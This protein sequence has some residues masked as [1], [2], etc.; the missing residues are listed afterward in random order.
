MPGVGGWLAGS[1][2]PPSLTLAP[3]PPG[4]CTLS[5]SHPP[6]APPGC[7]PYLC[8]VLRSLSQGPQ[9]AQGT[10]H[11]PALALGRFTAQTL[12]LPGARRVSGIYMFVVGPQNICSSLVPS[13]L[14]SGSQQELHKYVGH[15]RRGNPPSP[16]T[17]A[18]SAGGSWAG[19]GVSPRGGTKSRGWAGA[20][21]RGKLPRRKG[22]T[23]RSWC[24]CAQRLQNTGP[25][26]V[27]LCGQKSEQDSS[28][29][30]TRQGG[31]RD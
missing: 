20:S 3:R 21:P 27:T 23:G 15:K 22:G 2:D 28:V 31:L 19:T 14:S 8:A 6:S 10:G 13:P 9:T 16:S 17:A 12:F 4:H 7:P 24:P 30:P 18:G 11:H 1:E 25:P 5:M 26:G 29:L